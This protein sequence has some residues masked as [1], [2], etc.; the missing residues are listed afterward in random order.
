MRVEVKNIQP[1]DEIEEAMTKQMKAERD[2]R[3]TVTDATAHKEAV[4]ARAEGD[5]QAKVLAAEAEKEAQIALAQGRAESIR[6][7][8]EAEA[9]G[10]EKLKNANVTPTVLQLKGLEALKDVSD[11]RATKIFM[12]TDISNIVTTLGV[13]GESLGIGDATDINKEAKPKKELAVDPCLKPTSSEKTKEVSETSR[14]IQSELEEKTEKWSQNKVKEESITG[15]PRR[16]ANS[17]VTSRKYNA[18]NSPVSVDPDSLW[19]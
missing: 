6:L 18:T 15:T 9:Q 16:D 1:P 2:R 13:V 3:Q 4:V 8:Y 5:K 12:P 14:K 11:G 7:I 17:G 19:I 10:L